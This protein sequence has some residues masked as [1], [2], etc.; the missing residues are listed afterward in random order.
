MRQ[1]GNR[2]FALRLEKLPGWQFFKVTSTRV[3]QMMPGKTDRLG[4]VI[5]RRALRESR[6]KGFI[7]GA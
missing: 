4:L 5:H 3:R 1:S 6:L 2:I 7:F